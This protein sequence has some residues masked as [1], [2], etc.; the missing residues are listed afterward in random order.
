MVSHLCSAQTSWLSGV[1]SQRLLYPRSLQK[2]IQ[3]KKNRVYIDIYMYIY[4]LNF[5]ADSLATW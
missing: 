2:Q 4:S 5:H 3:S 1:T